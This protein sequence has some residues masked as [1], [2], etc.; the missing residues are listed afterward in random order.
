MKYGK[1]LRF[2]TMIAGG[3]RSGKSYL[4]EQF[5]ARYE[6]DTGPVLVYN[7]GR[8]GDNFTG[9]REVTF[10]TLEQSAELMKLPAKKAA[11]IKKLPHYLHFSYDRKVY[12]VKQLNRFLHL[13]R[14][15]KTPRAL[16]ILEEGRFF[17]TIFR[18]VTGCLLIID[19]S[20]PVVRNISDYRMTPIVELFSQ[21][22]HAGKFAGMKT[23]RQGIDIISIFHHPDK[24]NSEVY[25]YVTHVVI[26]P[27]TR[28]IKGA[29]IDND[30]ATEAMRAA[31]EQLKTMPRY[32]F[33]KIALKGE[34]AFIPI[35]HQPTTK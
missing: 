4:S 14:K 6:N 9:Y 18:Y 16:H 11:K 34:N 29:T 32:S 7:A 23:A 20:R 13:A 24:C 22:N 8:E 21:K 27:T 12:P 3:E 30:D 31:N 1:E 15:V 2:F 35:F 25:D 17:K 28:K 33:A 5:A 10:L 26:F 19:D